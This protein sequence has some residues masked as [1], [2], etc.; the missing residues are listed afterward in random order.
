MHRKVEP[1]IAPLFGIGKKV[2]QQRGSDAA[3]TERRIYSYG[4]D[5]EIRTA[6]RVTKGIPGEKPGP[7]R[8]GWL[9]VSLTDDA[10]VSP[11]APVLR[12][13]GRI[14][15]ARQSCK[16]LNGQKVVAGRRSKRDHA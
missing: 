16:P 9:S 11:T 3:A 13:A 15:P 10:E 1:E 4:H 7:G 14:Q 5:G 2:A 12:V 6:A 8:S